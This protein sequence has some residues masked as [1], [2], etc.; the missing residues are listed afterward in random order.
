VKFDAIAFGCVVDGQKPI[1]KTFDASFALDINEFR[2]KETLQLMIRNIQDPE[3]IAEFNHAEELTNKQKAEQAAAG[4]LP[5]DAPNQAVEVKAIAPAPVLTQP[6]VL[7]ISKDDP[8][9]REARID[10]LP[11]MKPGNRATSLR[12]EMQAMVAHVRQQ[13]MN[14]RNLSS[15]DGRTPS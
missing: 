7:K 3:Y 2:G 15:D 14:P 12:E 4:V 5:E 1:N 9:P 8:A 13:S 10:G 6:E 11:S